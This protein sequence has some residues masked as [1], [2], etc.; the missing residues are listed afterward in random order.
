MLAGKC[1]FPQPAENLLAASGGAAAVIVGFLATAK[2]IVLSI[3]GSRIYKA[4]K[5]A[6][7][8]DILLRFVLEAIAGSM[9]F[10]VV[11]ILGFFVA[12][13]LI[14]MP[15]WYPPVWFL[16]SSLSLFLFWRFTDILFKMLRW[17]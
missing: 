17:V 1:S 11:A 4:L 13:P 3:T 14:G 12:D 9:G 15:F 6:H 16:M 10:L 2:A 7:Y 5:E 8:T